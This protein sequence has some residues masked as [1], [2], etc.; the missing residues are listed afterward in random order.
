MGFF[1]HRHNLVELKDE[2]KKKKPKSKVIKELMDDTMHERRQWI[3][4]DGPSAQDVVI[5]YPPLRIQ[6]WVCFNVLRL[7]QI[8]YLFFTYVGEKRIPEDSRLC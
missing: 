3:E 6:R 2:M 7:L 1:S 8:I 5:M 4:K